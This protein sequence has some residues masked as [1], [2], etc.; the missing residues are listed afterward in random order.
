MGTATSAAT[1]PLTHRQEMS[2]WQRWLHH[3]ENLWLHRAL[4]QVHLWLGTLAALYVTVI[5][6]SGSMIVF[7]NQLE[8]SAAANSHRFRAIEWLVNFHENLLAGDVGRRLN[9]I[10]AIAFL[11]IC[12]TGA[13]IWWPGIAHWR[14]SLGV[15][16]RS[17]LARVNW[18]LHNMLGAWS[19]LFLAIWGLTGI[20]FAFP[21]LSYPL[22]DSDPSNAS[23]LVRFADA[24]LLWFTNLHFGRFGWPAEA[25]WTLIGLVPAVL[26]FTGVFMCCHRLL[27]RK[28][29]ALPR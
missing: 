26:V 5:S 10:G 8:S 17:S 29:A 6:L 11:L 7:R 12:L 15:N 18:D 19:F 16:W 9:G 1:A 27:I 4:F 20:Y 14:R 25:L 13:V 28:G 3:P 22:V 2:P 21:E 23:R 24:A